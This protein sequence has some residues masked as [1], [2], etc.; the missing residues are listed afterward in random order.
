ML[1]LQT[2]TVAELR[3]AMAERGLS[4]GLKKLKLWIESGSLPF[5]RVIQMEQTEYIILQKDFE[6]WAEE[7]SVEVEA[8]A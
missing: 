7:H 4:I 2:M 8:T 1:K 6:K 3:D 5:A